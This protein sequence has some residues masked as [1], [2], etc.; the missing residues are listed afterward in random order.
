MK[1]ISFGMISVL[2]TLLFVILTS[3]DSEVG[4]QPHSDTDSGA[5]SGAVTGRQ[6]AGYIFQFRDT[7]IAVDAP[8]A[9]LLEMLPAYRNKFV[10][11]SCVFESVET[12]YYYS[13]FQITTYVDEEGTERIYSIYLEDDS[14]QTPEGVC[15]GSLAEET[16]LIYGTPS[17]TAEQLLSFPKDHMVLSFVIKDGTV[18]SISYQLRLES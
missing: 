1:K 12:I 5:V 13:G 4:T 9:P 15:V 14:V 6:S 18:A 8:I 10:S 2:F 16:K 17:D 11:Q 3:C 7:E